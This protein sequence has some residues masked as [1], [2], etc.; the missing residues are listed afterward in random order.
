M[1]V[2]SILGI[3]EVENEMSLQL[4]LNLAWTDARLTM[5]DLKDDEDLNTLTQ[6]FKEVIWIPQVSRII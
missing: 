5:Y 4:R 1:D 2:I 3:K 6:E